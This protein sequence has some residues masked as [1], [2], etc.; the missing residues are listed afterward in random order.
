M[1]TAQSMLFCGLC[2]WYYKCSITSMGK[3][4]FQGSIG[5]AGAEDI[6]FSDTIGRK[7]VKS[8]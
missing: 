8:M 1:Q 3:V 2:L 7:K 6:T 4:R 5:V